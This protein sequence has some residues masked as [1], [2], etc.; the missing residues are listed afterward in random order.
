MLFYE[1][2]ILKSME[3]ASLS[4]RES[5]HRRFLEQECMKAKNKIERLV[6][7]K[8]KRELLYELV[9]AERLVHRVLYGNNLSKAD[10]SGETLSRIMSLLIENGVD[11]ERL[12]E[13]EEIVRGEDPWE[14]LK[15]LMVELHNMARE[16]V[17]ADTGSG[18]KRLC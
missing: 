2:E 13:V 5:V 18:G 15:K 8:R 1:Q 7:D 10:E 14:G 3:S 9:K 4:E 6:P 12:Y 11:D 17:F 16:K